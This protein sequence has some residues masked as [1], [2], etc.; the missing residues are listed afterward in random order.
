M[1]TCNT[2]GVTSA[3]P[4][5]KGVWAS[6]TLT[7]SAKHNASV[8]SRRFARPW[9]PSGRAGPFV[10]KHGSPTVNQPSSIELELESADSTRYSNIITSIRV[11]QWT[12][13]QFD[14]ISDL[15]TIANTIANVMA[16]VKANGLARAT[17]K[18]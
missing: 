5:F 6:G 17:L 4:P 14:L 8:V 13:V 1:D 16:N 12:Q 10:P 2:R 9:Y 7:H 18:F 15:F 11:P 3:L